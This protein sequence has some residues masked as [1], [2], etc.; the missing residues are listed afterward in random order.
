M[1][2]PIRPVISFEPS[3]S[4]VSKLANE[5]SDALSEDFG[6]LYQIEFSSSKGIG[7]AESLVVTITGAVVSHFIVRLLD[8]LFRRRSDSQNRPDVRVVH[9]DTHVLFLL[10]RDSAEIVRYF[11]QRSRLVGDRQEG[12]EQ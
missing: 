10:P 6:D 5:V 9:I 11:E 1:T 8:L 2:D 3:G 4:Q 7:I 12:T